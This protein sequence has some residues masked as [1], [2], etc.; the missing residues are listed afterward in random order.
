MRPDK[1]TARSLLTLEPI[2]QKPAFSVFIIWLLG[3]WAL[4]PTLGIPGMRDWDESIYASV[5]RNI[6]STGD[7]IKLQ[8]GDAPYFNKPP[9]F[10][11]LTAGSFN[12]FGVNEFSARLISALF[13][14]GCLLIGYALV[15]KLVSERVA[16]F[17]SL[18]VLAHAQ[19]IQI[20]Q[21]GRMESMVTFFILLACYAM[22]RIPENARW[23]LVFFISLAAGVL[24]KGVFALIP[25]LLFISLSVYSH[26]FRNSVCSF[27]FLI[28]V[29][30]FL[31]S[32]LPWFYLEYQ[33]YG[34]VYLDE[35]WGR[36]TFTRITTAFEGHN[37]GPFYYLNR[38]SFRYFSTWAFLIIPALIYGIWKWFRERSVG[39]FFL[40]VF[41]WSGLLFFSLL[42]GTKLPWYVYYLY[43]P[44]ATLCVLM[45]EDI[46]DRFV[47]FRHI[48]FGLSFLYILI[49]GVLTPDK[50]QGYK[51]FRDEFARNLPMGKKLI[52]FNLDFPALYF[53]ANC[54]VE[55]TADLQTFRDKLQT[56]P[57]CFISRTTDFEKLPGNLP[58]E[59]LAKNGEYVFFRRKPGN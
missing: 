48:V 8:L 29:L 16:F 54:P 39:L 5:A 57:S 13:A 23:W 11:V 52:S 9:L 14:I 19:F 51:P 17:S 33:T 12:L 30:L 18:L 46:P 40:N 6:L 21:H 4:F 58:V 59:I 35:F 22:F 20:S 38:L 2:I 26:K 56:E 31:V 7:M 27:W 3:T 44:L 32:S 42:V 53:Y 28:G 1:L 36:Q 43:I 15:R 24:T 37:G 10:M 41:I 49:S 34:T 47:V 45:L 25:V 55:N 50:F